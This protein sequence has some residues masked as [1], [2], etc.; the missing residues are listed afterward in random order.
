MATRLYFHSESF[1]E[2]GIYPT[3]K[4]SANVANTTATT[5]NTLRQL[6]LTPELNQSSLVV[7]TSATTTP[8]KAF[9]GYFCSPI[10]YEDQVVGSG[11]IKIN[12][13]DT[14][15]NTIAA[16]APN[17]ASIYVWNPSAGNVRGYITDPGGP[18]ATA[19]PSTTAAVEQVSILHYNVSQDGVLNAQ[20]VV[21]QGGDVIICEIWSAHTQSMATSY[22]G[23]IYFG[24]RNNLNTVENQ[25]VSDHA[26]YIEFSENLT[27]QT[28][29]VEKTIKVPVNFGAVPDLVDNVAT[30]IGTP[31]IYIPENSPTYPIKIADAMLYIGAQD[32]ST[33]TGATLGTLTAACV[34]G[35]TGAVTSSVTIPS[36]LT[37]TG[38]NWGGVFGPIDFS[39]NFSQYFGSNTSAV[40]SVRLTADVT[41]GTGLNLRGV[42]GYLEITYEYDT[43][44]TVNRIQTIPIPY[45][46]LTGT[47][48]AV[49]TLFA[50]SPQLSGSGGYLQNYG[51]TTIRHRWLELKGN[52]NTAGGVTDFGITASFAGGANVI[53]PQREATFASD[54]YQI[55]QLDMSALS[56]TTT[57][58]INLWNSLATR[59]ANL[60]VTEWVSFEYT[61]SNATR[62]LNYQEIP[63]S[64]QTPMSIVSTNP[65][66]IY[67]R[68]LIPETG[69]LVMKQSALELNYSTDSGNTVQVATGLT[70]SFRGYAQTS[71]VTCGQFGLQHRFDSAAAGGNALTLRTGENVLQTRLYRSAGTTV[72]NPTGVIK[73]VYESDIDSEFGIDYHSAT[74]AG[75][76]TQVNLTTV[77][78][79]Y[80]TTGSI[81]IPQSFYNIESY[82]MNYLMWQFGAA[83]VRIPIRIQEQRLA[84][85]LNSGSYQTIYSDDLLSDGELS[86]ESIVISMPT[87]NSQ[88]ARPT[89]SFSEPKF[90]RAYRL[91][92]AYGARFGVRRFVTYNGIVRYVAGNIQSAEPTLPITLNLYRTDTMELLESKAVDPSIT[93]FTFIVYDRTVPY[94]VTAY[95]NETYNGMSIISTPP[96]G[97]TPYTIDLA[98][99][100]GGGETFF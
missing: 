50:T 85:E 38:E 23:T 33:A 63:F 32:T 2:S 37:N 3:A 68:I 66:V 87:Y 59:F 54:T 24:G 92:S 61:S 10:L 96:P 80:G 74:R 4:Q 1:S 41:T 65:D 89:G 48:P 99:A 43:R 20:P 27:F 97:G 9:M 8:Q 25:I 100:G 60:V 21:A 26:S 75:M 49:S 57:N 95:Q 62:V 42:Y 6:E 40:C 67:T 79:N 11:S 14:Q 70:G 17:I 39:Q 47:L 52:C 22:N 81:T 84:G 28:N 55:Y 90:Q 51:P 64:A 72:S 93:S 30:T 58:T 46:S 12:I 15:S 5:A 86:Y 73:L 31:T 13:A 69:S 82:G 83:G 71:T 91:S 76:V 36:V 19:L 44:G 16:F 77:T 29:V 94:M 56:T 18:I 98:A 78:D 34:L 45:D 7:A 88:P 53:L 35:I